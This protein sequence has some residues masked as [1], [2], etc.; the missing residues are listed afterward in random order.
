MGERPAAAVRAGQ[1]ADTVNAIVDHCEG[2]GVVFVIVGTAL[3]RL[4]STLISGM[5]RRVTATASTYRLQLWYLEPLSLE[6]G[7]KPDNPQL[8]SQGRRYMGIVLE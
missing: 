6:S 5:S 3:Y 4:D 8:N 7:S 1:S 2:G